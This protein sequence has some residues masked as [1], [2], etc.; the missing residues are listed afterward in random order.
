MIVVLVLL[1]PEMTGM[2]VNTFDGNEGAKKKVIANNPS[3]TAWSKHV[4][5]KL[6][7]IRGLLRAENVRVLHVRTA[8]QHADA[9][10]KTV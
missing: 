1:Q 5:V 8:E 7:F 3:S 9:L 6:H 4:D 2:R 10:T